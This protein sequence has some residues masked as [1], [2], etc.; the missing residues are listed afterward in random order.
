MFIANKAIPIA[1]MNNRKKSVPWWSNELGNLIKKRN[2]A[3]STMQ[4]HK[5]P[6]NIKKFKDIKYLVSYSILKAKKDSWANFCSSIKIGAP[7]SKAWSKIKRLQGKNYIKQVLNNSKIYNT[8]QKKANIFAE[9]FRNNSSTNNFEKIFLNKK[10]NLEK[11]K[12]PLDAKYSDPKLCFNVPF[13]KQEFIE[14]FKNRKNSATGPDNFTYMFFKYMP[15]STLDIF[16]DLF[17][18]IWK[19]GY[20]PLKWKVADI[21]SLH[22][23]G[24]D[25]GNPLNYRPISLTSNVCKTMEAMVNARLSHYLEINNLLS[26]FQSGFR[27]H[28]S[29]NDHLVRLQT[30]INGAF[31][32]GHKTIAVFVDIEKAY[33]MVWKHGLLEK[34]YKLGIRGPMFNFIEKF[35]TQRSF[36]V[37]VG[38]SFSPVTNLENGIPQGSVIAPTL[39]SIYINDL[40][41]V[42]TGNQK[43]K[44]TK[45]SIGLFADDAAFWRTGKHIGYLKKAIQTDLN[46]LQN[47]S[48]NWGI[49]L[50]KSKTV[51]IIFKNKITRGHIPLNL[52]LNNSLLAQVK[53]VKFLGVI[54]DQALTFKPHINYVVDTC[55]SGLNLL[56]VLCGTNWG[57]DRKTLLCIYNAYVVSRLQYGAPA[58][59]CAKPEALARLDVVQS[60]ALKTIANTYITTPTDSIQVELG[61]MPL[62]LLRMKLCFNYWAKVKNIT[63]QNPVNALTPEL[64]PIIG[65]KCK[66]TEGVGDSFIT[67]MSKLAIACNTDQISLSIDQIHFQSPWSIPQPK[68]SFKLREEVLKTDYP[69]FRN[70]I[71]RAAAND[72]YNSF[73]HIYTDGSKDPDTGKTG[74]AFYVE[75]LPP[76]KSFIGRARLNDNISVY[77]T[78]LTAILHALIWIKSN[79]REFSNYVIF[80]DSLSALMAIGGS[81]S[82]RKDLIN[83]I[84]YVNK[85]LMDRGLNIIFEWVPAHVGIVGNEKADFNAKKSLQ[86]GSVGININY[87]FKEIGSLATSFLI[88]LWQ[89]EWNTRRNL[90][91][92]NL[93]PLVSKTTQT[94]QSRKHLKIITRLRVGVIR[95]LGDTKFKIKQIGSPD[96]QICHTKDTVRHFLLECVKYNKERG[97]LLAEFGSLGI[98]PIINNILNPPNDIRE[99]VNKILFK[100]LHMTNMEF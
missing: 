57:A 40:A 21:F 30:E 47:W 16:L 20:I 10:S 92:H 100:F 59:C 86:D 50:S 79:N 31:G 61:V 84:I 14:G 95:G 6:D 12:I 67:K 34:I 55:K 46:N 11:N 90:H 32:K 44:S 69:P 85:S 1:A 42:M 70:V 97:I 54:F 68:V 18:L 82:V 75:P 94:H 76:M 96:C 37:D 74:M 83:K 89:Q 4:K 41:T 88:N 71:F 7:S 91:H 73:V 99:V 35:I 98:K 23:T 48:E 2:K 38:G 33:D 81:N 3:R 52:M 65:Q 56:R 8:N 66:S 93:Q 62:S 53:Q 49:K 29:T 25:P 45:F 80:S 13:T 26:P 27:K 19:Q 64:T 87:N 77:A 58:F 9:T 39:F 17:N 72:V 5:S 51:S 78:E 60:K 63:P 36:R 43:Y 22:K 24:K 15:D 28:H